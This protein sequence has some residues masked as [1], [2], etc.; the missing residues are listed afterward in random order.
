MLITFLLCLAL[1]PHIN[2]HDISDNFLWC[3]EGILPFSGQLRYRAFSLV[4]S[5]E[6]NPLFISQ[7]DIKEVHRVDLWWEKWPPDVELG[8]WSNGLHF[9]QFTKMEGELYIWLRQQIYGGW[10]ELVCF[11]EKMVHSQ[12]SKENWPAFSFAGLGLWGIYTGWLCMTWYCMPPL[13]CYGRK[14]SPRK[15]TV[16]MKARAPPFVFTLQE[17]LT[18]TPYVR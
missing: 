1:W 11:I 5:L 4:T 16:K 14:A 8:F 10:D 12:K 3:W 18:F 17:Y 15:K 6:P 9:S 13:F 7:R 2:D